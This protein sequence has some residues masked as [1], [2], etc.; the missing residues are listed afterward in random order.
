[1]EVESNDRVREEQNL[2]LIMEGLCNYRVENIEGLTADM[3]CV[4]DFVV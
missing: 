1:M 4:F 3:K 2:K